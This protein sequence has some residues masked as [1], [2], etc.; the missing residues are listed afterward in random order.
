MIVESPFV[1]FQIATRMGCS[2]RRYH[3]PVVMAKSG[4]HP[5]SKRPSRKRQARSAPYV[6]QTDM[7]DSAMP[8]PKTSIGIR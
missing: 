4:K 1:E 6:L 2:A 5:A 3:L 7:H 8:Q